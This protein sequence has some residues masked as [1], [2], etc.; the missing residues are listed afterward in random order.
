MVRSKSE[1]VIANMLYRMD[2]EYEYERLYEGASAP[3]RR[4]PDFSFVDAAG[5]LVLWE[6]LGMMTRDDYRRD[7]DRKREWYEQNGFVL[8]EN[9]L[10]TEDDEQGGLDSRAVKKVAE[11]IQSLI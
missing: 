3:G 10:T 1:L 9:L 5:D 2:V 8:G 7:W 4:R 11:K 6:H